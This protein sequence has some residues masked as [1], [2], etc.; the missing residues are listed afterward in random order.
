MELSNLIPGV[1][2]AR[3]DLDTTAGTR[4]HLSILESFSRGDSDVLLGT[5]M[6]AKGHHYP[7]VTL[8][9]VVN[10]DGGLNFPD[11]RAAE[12][13]FQLL[14]QAA[15]RTGRGRKGGRV[16][17]QTY[18]PEHYLYDHLRALDFEGF[19]AR[20]LALRY[21]L[22]YPPAKDLVLFT[23]T[24]TARDDAAQAADRVHGTLERRF[25]GASVE[26]L[27]PVPALVERVRGRYRSQ[28]LVRGTL[29]GAGKE[30]MVRIARE[31]VSGYAR[32]DLR[33]DVDPLTLV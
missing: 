31:S 6:V 32:T 27:G 9:G 26:C 1:R 19:A 13:T 2:I 16:I 7:S 10:A 18:A 33:W 12:R 29:D 21:E 5:Q 28:V 25:S 3:M 8:V 22:G 4:G 24:S 20:E 30:E 23:V 11:F 17:V 14:Y 15:G